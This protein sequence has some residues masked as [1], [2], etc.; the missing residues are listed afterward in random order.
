MDH[1]KNHILPNQGI[2]HWIWGIFLKDNPEELIGTVGLWRQGRPSN[3]GFW[4]GK[5]FWGQGIM[6]E[7]VMPVMDYAFAEL[8][9]KK[10]VFTNALGNNRSR[11]IKEKTG[12]HLVDVK[13]AKYVNPKYLEQ[14]IWELTREEWQQF[15]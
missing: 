9:F 3:R 7:A 14:E 6:T 15:S 1:I 8:D 11:R 2:D 5:K 13:P 10:L 4:L 12:A